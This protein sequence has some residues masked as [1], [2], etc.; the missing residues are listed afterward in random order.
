M[1]EKKEKRYV[2]IG[3]VE[4]GLHGS[5]VWIGL[6][7]EAEMMGSGTKALGLDVICLHNARG[8]IDVE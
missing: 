7:G 2:N 5:L 4:V 1:R 6:L 8:R 3:G